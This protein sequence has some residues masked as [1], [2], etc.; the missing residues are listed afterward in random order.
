MADV[1]GSVY[2]IN[3]VKVTS[4]DEEVWS[5]IVLGENLVPLERRSPYE[6]LQWRKTVAERCDL[7]W[8]DFAEQV[9]TSLTCTPP[10]EVGVHRVFTQSQVLLSVA[11]RAGRGMGREVVATFIVDT[12]DTS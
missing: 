9:L 3:G 6:Q 2:E 4:P 7:D 12:R 1:I 5:P 11:M 10:R 8:F